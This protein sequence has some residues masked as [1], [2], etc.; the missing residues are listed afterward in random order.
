M[1]Y[2]A[3]LWDLDGT[4][5]DTLGDLTASVNAA[6]AT[7]DLPPRSEREVCTFV[8]NGIRRLIERAVP[9]GCDPEKVEAVFHAFCAHYE[10]HC[11]DTTRPYDGILPLLAR[12]KAAGV[13]SAVVSNKA[14]IAVKRLVPQHFGNGI[15]VAIGATDR[16]PPKP[17]PDM[18]EEALCQLGVSREEVLYIG[19]SEVDI[20]TARAAGV[21]SVIV[22]WGFRTPEQLTGADRLVHS[23]PELER[24]LFAPPVRP[25]RA[26]DIPA[27]TA[28][29]NEVVRDGVAFPQTEEMTEDEAAAFFAAQDFCGVAEDESG[30][31]GLYILHP[32]NIGRC[33]HIGNA[34]YAVA[35]PAR[36]RGFGEALV[37]HS[38]QKA[39][40]LGF[41][42]MQFNAV[43]A[44]N[45][46]AL[47]LYP[48][49][50]FQRLGTIPGGFLMPDGH[51]E[52]IV[53]F[54][55]DLTKGA[56]GYE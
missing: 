36:G 3:I 29:W 55:Y 50:G 43:V 33:G 7:Q 16:L 19:D 38:L 41:R 2:K 47:H 27:M 1:K 37:A 39:R 20:A 9:A 22:T 49:L 40:E 51:Y 31:Q 30:V 15:Q 4:L 28:I 52:D 26:A 18:V 5:L 44:A 17:A 42:L 56:N 46:V 45:R 21:D 10:T 54:Y 13:L 48:K 6:L 34:S 14:D 25:Y 53:L 12:L 11:W 8:G 24:Y 35:S 32:N 23:V